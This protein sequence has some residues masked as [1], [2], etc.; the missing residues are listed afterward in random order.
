MSID[1]VIYVG[2]FIGEKQF[3]YE[4]FNLLSQHGFTP[5]KIGLFEPVREE[6]S[7][8]RAATLWSIDEGH[9]AL[10]VGG[11]MAK[12]KDPRILID[13]DWRREKNAAPSRN[14]ISFIFTQKTNRNYSENILLLFKELVQST[15]AIYAYISHQNPRAR[16]HV[17]GTI[18]S[19]M[20]G[21][22]WCNYYGKPFVEFFGREK[23]LNGPWF[24]TEETNQGIYTFLTEKPDKELLKKPEIELNAQRYLNPNSFGDPALD[25]PN[26]LNWKPQ[27]KEMPT[28]IVPDFQTEA[29]PMEE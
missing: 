1:I 8:E 21:V 22:F 15:N 20:P 13:C 9:N 26:D 6:Y 27:Q 7:L 10:N 16:Q 25:D 14:S 2:K 24:S 29:K 4:F 12:K 11:M 23:L 19:R 18:E 28:L 17:I 5:D 3:A